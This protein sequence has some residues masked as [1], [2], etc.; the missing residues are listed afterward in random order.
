MQNSFQIQGQKNKNRLSSGPYW[1][2]P[3]AQQ[4]ATPRRRAA[5]A[6]PSGMHYPDAASLHRLLVRLS[7][8]LAALLGHAEG[9]EMISE[10]E[11]L[12]RL[13]AAGLITYPSPL[14]RGLLEKVPEV[15]LSG[16][17][18]A[19]LGHA[20]GAELFSEDTLL[21]WLREA[22]LI[23]YP[24]PVL[25]RLLAELPDVL[26]AEVLPWLDP[27][28]LAVLAQVGRAWLAAVVSSGLARAGK[29]AGVPLILNKRIF[30]SVG[31]LAWA[32]DN[33]CPWVTRTCSL[34]ALYSRGQVE[35]L[36][37]AREND[38]PWD[39]RTC[40]IA[41]AGGHLAV[42]QWAW[43][44]GCDWDEM[45]CAGAA[46]RGQLEVL[47]WARE[48]GCP[49]N[50]DNEDPGLNCCA[51]AAA[52]GHLAVLRWAR[53]YGCPWNASTCELRRQ[54]GATGSAQMGAVAQVRVGCGDV[55]RR[56]TVWAPGGAAVGAGERLPVESLDVSKSCTGRAPG[57]VAVDAG[58]RLRLG[59]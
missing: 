24:S 54:M 13:G 7:G 51:L 58:A 16:V 34:A 39:E 12:R 14:L 49:W 28:D 45:T 6:D 17:L 37:W 44:H 29:S 56:R 40:R 35:V 1:P 53:I 52:G 25:G 31:W 21:G 43:E 41:A 5:H 23:S 38:C 3:R 46:Y 42:L 11:L 20:E 19:L 2:Q 36:R 26:A 8:A 22:G 55:S 27:T 50:E 59:R 32:K 47:K 4:P 10:D 33:G 30:R 18:A 9:A 48:H 15:C 57:G